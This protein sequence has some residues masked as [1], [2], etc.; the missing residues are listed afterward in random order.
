MVIA[1]PQVGKFKDTVRS[2]EAVIK[3]LEGLLEGALR[4]GQEAAGEQ[5]KADSQDMQATGN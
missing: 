2:Q 4:K 3:R 5:A 1:A